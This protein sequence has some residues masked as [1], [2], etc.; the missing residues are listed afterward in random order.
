[1]LALLVPGVGMGGG[2]ASSVV[3][4]PF[5]FTFA[6]LYCAGA[7]TGGVY[8]PGGAAGGGVYAGGAAWGQVLVS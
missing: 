4:G 7:T 5:Y 6:G 3:A 1:M 2:A 8:A